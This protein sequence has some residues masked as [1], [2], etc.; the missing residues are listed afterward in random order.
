[1][2]KPSATTVLLGISMCFM[3]SGAAEAGNRKAQ[4]MVESLQKDRAELLSMFPALKLVDS[5]IHADC[6]AKN[7]AKLTTAQFCGCAAAVT[8][9]LWR[10]GGDPKMMTRLNDFLR[11]PSDAGAASL[12]Q[13]QGPE[14]YRGICKEAVRR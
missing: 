8:V 5:A 6:A 9:G 11:D 10:S 3:V 1:M 14:L 4:R 13:Y 2:M 7:E 12:L